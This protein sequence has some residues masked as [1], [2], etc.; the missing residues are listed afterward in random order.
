MGRGESLV[1]VRMRGVSNL[2]RLGWRG[3]HLCLLV[4]GGREL[5][6]LVRARE[7]LVRMG[8]GITYMCIGQVEEVAKLLVLAE[9]YVSQVKGRSKEWNHIF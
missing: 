9:M 4:W 1:L 5:L 7:I 6:L 8:E 3:N 2:Y